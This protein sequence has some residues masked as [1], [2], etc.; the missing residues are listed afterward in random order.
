MDTY[1]K[2]T[3]LRYEPESALGIIAPALEEDGFENIETSAD[4]RMLP[5]TKLNAKGREAR[6]VVWVEPAV[7]GS[8]VT[9]RGAG[10]RVA[11]IFKSPA[12]D[13]VTR[14]IKAMGAQ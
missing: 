13:A 10:H 14:A 8:S 5:A 1:E 6:V 7:A 4:G 2:Q 9:V 3:M 12:R 11:A